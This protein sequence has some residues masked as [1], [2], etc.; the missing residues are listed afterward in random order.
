MFIC[1]SYDMKFY[2]DSSSKVL[3]DNMVS[4]SSP[5]PLLNDAMASRRAG[6][7]SPRM[8]WHESCGESGGIGG[9]WHRV[10]RN[11]AGD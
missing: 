11:Q 7:R 10:K 3:A 9:N 4:M 5:K 6:G 2:H 1:G 8:D